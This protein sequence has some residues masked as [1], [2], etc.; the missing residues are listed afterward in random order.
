MYEPARS[1]V[2]GP[3]RLEVHVVEPVV[4]HVLAHARLAA[5]PVQLDQRRGAHEVLGERELAS[6]EGD[7]LDL[8]R[9]LRDALVGAHAAS[10]ATAAANASVCRSTCSSVVAG[11]ISAMLWNGVISTP[12]FIR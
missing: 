2:F 12:R 4:D 3:S 7:R 6:L 11:H 5:G 9:Q 1:I 8:E 10:S